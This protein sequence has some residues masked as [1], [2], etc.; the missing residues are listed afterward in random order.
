MVKEA[1]R[2]ESKAKE[3]AFNEYQK[4]AGEIEARDVANRDDLSAEERKNIRPDIDNPNVVFADGSSVSYFAKSEYNAETAVASDTVKKIERLGKLDGDKITLFGANKEA[5]NA[6]LRTLNAENEQNMHVSDSGERAALP[7]GLKNVDP[8]S[9]TEDEVKTLL[10][11][12]SKKL[13]KDSSY[14]PVRINTPQILIETAASYGE[15]IENLPVVMQVEK[16][17]Q[18]MSN[19]E[20]WY[21]ENR[22]TRPHNLTDDDIISI[23]RAMNTPKYIVYQTDNERYVEIVKYKSKNDAEA[24]AVIEIGEDKNPEYLNG[25]KGGKYQVLITAFNPDENT[26]DSILNNSN[27]RVLYPKKKKGSSQRGSG[28]NVPSHLNDSPF[29]NS[30]SQ[31]IEN[32]NTFDEN[33]SKNVDDGSR[34][35]LKKEGESAAEKKLRREVERAK[36]KY[37]RAVETKEAQLKAEYTTDTVFSQSSV[38]SGFD[39][40]AEVKKLPAKVREEIARDLWLELAASDDRDVRGTFILKYSVKLYDAIRRADPDAYDNMTIAERD[41][42]KDKLEAAMKKIA[43]SGKKS[44][45]AK[46]KDDVRGAYSITT[47]YPQNMQMCHILYYHKLSA[48]HADEPHTRRSEI[49]L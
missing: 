24:I 22:T 32:D 18:A 19:E 13:Y 7:D 10:N 49:F 44:K 45:W 43:N 34:A 31:K 48:K 25:Y 6:L 9:V 17:R 16:V 3:I 33:S 11:R 20:Q 1:L 8:T 47:N 15:K 35:A 30:I 5:E 21:G 38:K 14:I 29:A 40:V 39:S 26:I 23:I 41:A 28:N 46:Q 4:L 37:E 42:L 36:E 2:E 27:N 12:A